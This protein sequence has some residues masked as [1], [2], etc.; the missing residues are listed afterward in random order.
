VA[1]R[2]P[3]WTLRK[4]RF[5]LLLPFYFVVGDRFEPVSSAT[6]CTPATAGERTQDRGW[7]ANAERSMPMCFISR[8]WKMAQWAPKI[9]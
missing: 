7:M 2:V 8:S 1:R 3:N 4:A 9:Q 6:A 5:F